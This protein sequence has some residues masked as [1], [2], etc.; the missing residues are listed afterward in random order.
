M[1][2]AAGRWA[3]PVTDL[4]RL[5]RSHARWQDALEP[6]G[7]PSQWLRIRAN[8][9]WNMPTFF[10]FRGQVDLSQGD[11]KLGW[12]A[13]EHGSN[14]RLTGSD[15][16][17]RQNHSGVVLGNWLIRGRLLAQPKSN[18]NLGARP[19]RTF[20]RRRFPDGQQRTYL[21]PHE[22]S[23]SLTG[24]R[25]ARPTSERFATAPF[26]FL[27]A[28]RQTDR[29]RTKASAAKPGRWLTLEG[30]GSLLAPLGSGSCASGLPRSRASCRHGR[31]K[32]VPGFCLSKGVHLVSN[33]YGSPPRLAASKPYVSARGRRR[34]SDSQGCGVV[35][36]DLYL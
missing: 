18:G 35:S 21:R 17:Q 23:W 29:C 28:H 19:V 14:A 5:L 16:R 3:N 9:I 15:S 22:A 1:P 31:S 27:S 25:A 33:T 12:Q 10:G 11:K 24:R 30:F 6:Q 32:H 4:M 13:R 34:F 36:A 8:C 2:S 20:S 7:S 26:A